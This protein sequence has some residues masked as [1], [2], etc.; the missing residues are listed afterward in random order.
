MNALEYTELAKDLEFP[1]GPV[2]LPDGDLLVVEIHRGTLTRVTLQG[3]VTV[4]AECG[5]GPNGAAMAPDGSIFVCNNGGFAW[6]RLG[7][8]LIPLGHDPDTYT[9]GRIQRVD[10]TTG[11]VEDVYTECDGRPLRSPNDLVFD[12]HG[13]FWFSDSGTQ[14]ERER[15]R[16]GVFYAAADGSGIR[17]AIFPSEIPNGI[18][19]SPDGSRLYVAESLTGRIF[20]WDLAGPGDPVMTPGLVP[21]GGTLLSNP[22]GLTFF[23][24]L[25]VEENGNVC[26]ATVGQGGVI[27]VAPDGTIVERHTTDDPLTT[28]LCFGGADRRTA[29][30][31]LGATGRLVAAAWPR[32]G[33]AL[34]T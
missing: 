5:G 23:D 7:P 12:R 24:S 2:V 11:A 18:G 25:A 31:T 26:V 13:G 27:V 19:L 3:D 34:A 1:E 22:P 21:G 16:T 29:Y 17:E 4:V 10:L 32:P 14:R 20:F 9:G 15:D 8:L 30:I 28:N 6:E 33:L